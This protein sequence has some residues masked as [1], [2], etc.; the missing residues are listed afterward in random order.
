MA[1]TFGGRLRSDVTCCGCGYTST[2]HEPFLDIS[3]DIDAPAEPPPPLLRPAAPPAQHP[4]K[5][6][7][8]R[9]VIRNLTAELNVIFA[10]VWHERSGNREEE[11][12]L[13]DAAGSC[14]CVH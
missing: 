9:D 6:D 14:C 3:L 12:G 1:G 8:T 2:V 4:P 10:A 11:V 5:C 13:G 7:V